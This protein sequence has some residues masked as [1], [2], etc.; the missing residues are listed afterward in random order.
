MSEWKEIKISQ[1]SKRITS[2]GTPS[3]K[4][5]DYFDGSIPWLNSKEINFNRIETTEKNITEEGLKNSSA[6]WI[7]E[8][9]VI[10]AMYGATAAKVAV[11]K[12]S[13]KKSCSVST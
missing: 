13:A 2:G 12:M 3:T 5:S 10:V 9:S 8:N 4:N 11:N 6:K 1:I 7:D